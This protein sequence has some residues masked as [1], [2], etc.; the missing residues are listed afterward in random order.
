MWLNQN[1]E[2]KERLYALNMTNKE[3]YMVRL[4]VTCFI[5]LTI[6]LS[7]DTL[8]IAK[9]QLYATRRWTQRQR[10]PA[11][12]FLERKGFVKGKIQHVLLQLLGPN[13][14]LLTYYGPKEPRDFYTTDDQQ[15]IKN[16]KNCWAP[17][18]YF[19]NGS[20]SIPYFKLSSKC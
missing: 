9:N 1:L 12:S 8:F 16:H 11:S 2:W 7:H 6:T 5:D 17:L 13:F 4:Q 19:K 15:I 18:L 14:V 3:D 20:S 10:C